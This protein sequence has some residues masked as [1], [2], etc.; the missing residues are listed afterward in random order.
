MA[1]GSAT[2]GWTLGSSSCLLYPLRNF[3]TFGTLNFLKNGVIQP[4][5]LMRTAAQDATYDGPG[6]EFDIWGCYNIPIPT[7]TGNTHKREVSWE[8]ENIPEFSS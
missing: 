7:V 6:T 3:S 1:L 4:R 8:L 2:F 5:F